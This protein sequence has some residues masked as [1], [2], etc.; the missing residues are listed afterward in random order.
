VHNWTDNCRPC[1]E[2]SIGVFH[3]L[4]YEDCVAPG[5]IVIWPF[6]DSSSSSDIEKYLIDLLVI[7]DKGTS[8]IFLFANP[9][10]VHNLSGVWHNRLY[11]NKIHLEPVSDV[12]TVISCLRLF[13]RQ[14]R[15]IKPLK[16]TTLRLPAS[17]GTDTKDLEDTL[18]IHQL[19]DG[20]E[21]CFF[22]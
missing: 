2:K 21:V 3:Q 5:I 7:A 22:L 15:P 11:T 14:P 17:G 20:V 8:H 10:L 1:V 9:T 18:Q 13:M 19:I 6:T 12:S 16:P 4:C